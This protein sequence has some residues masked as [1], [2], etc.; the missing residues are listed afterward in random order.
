ME[1]MLS[2]QD[3]DDVQLL[4]IAQDG[5][6]EAF[7]ELYERHAQAVFRY[8]Y[9]HLNDRLD[10]EDLTEEVFLR[11]WRTL[12]AYTE[13]GVPFLA[14]LFRIAHNAL[15]D[16]YRR[17]ARS[18]PQMSLET[19]PLTDFRPDPGDQA[20]FNLEHQ[21]VRR[22]LEQLREDYRTVL[23]LRFLSDLSPGETAHVMER[24]EG[25]VRILQHRALA[26]LR[27]LLEGP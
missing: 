1:S 15:I 7:G 21:E 4:K 3:V 25:A 23:I 24:T 9:A 19:N 27:N 17:S 6:A 10:A 22:T 2:W 11:V 12:S 26:A 18:G 20:M 16:F 13:Q 14:Y 5:E 8:L